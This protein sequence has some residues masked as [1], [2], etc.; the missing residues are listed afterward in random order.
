MK[1]HELGS[2]ARQASSAMSLAWRCSRVLILLAGG[3]AAV[4]GALPV[5]AG[6]LMKSLL[7][8][9]TL[10]EAQSHVLPLA[11]PLAVL[12]VLQAALPHAEQYVRTEF[13]RRVGRL[14]QKE[15]FSSI[16]RFVGMGP[17]ED[18]AFLDRLRLAQRSGSEGP[19]RAVT[20]MVGTCRAVITVVG[21]LGSLMFLGPVMGVCV[22]LFAIPVVAAEVL[23]SRRR[24]AMLWAVSPTERREHFYHQLLSSAEAAKEVRLFG[25]GGFLLSRMQR[26]R[27]AA[28]HAKRSM[29]RR[30]LLVQTCLVGTAAV[31]VGIGLVWAIVQAQ[32]GE[33]SVG[34]ISIFV[35]AAAG[36]QMALTQLAA[37]VGGMHQAL[38][39][40]RHYMEISGAGP[41]LAVSKNP[42]TLPRLRDSI[43]LR[44]V[45][46]RYSDSH[47]WILR[48]VNLKIRQGE[49]L[50]VVGLNG[51]GKS[52]L[53]KLLCRFY[54][55]TRG[56]VRWDGVDIREVDPTALRQRMAAV[57]QD[58]MQYDLTVRENIGLGELSAM[59]DQQRIERAARLAGVDRTVSDLP[60]G[61]ETLLTRFFFSAAEADNPET[62]VMLSGG[63]GQR[64]AL[65]RGFVRGDRD[66][67][68]LD[69]PS[70]GLDAEAEHEIHSSLKRHRADR[71]SLLISHRLGSVRDADRIVV[72][73]DG[74]IMEEGDHRTLM[75]DK[76]EYARLF[77]LQ[78]SGYA[79]DP[80]QPELAGG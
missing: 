3:L 42:R 11:V 36:V 57:F 10:G 79:V 15:L 12:G 1:F 44:D 14:A 7:D 13:D 69:E 27:S 4:S 28:D 58:Y 51:S 70:S 55:P 80:A 2:L 54:D 56:S 60:H 64:I 29:D 67:M 38:T 5:A 78:A 20:S 47:P 71:T 26:E 40:Y 34:D 22:L 35:A 43:E 18:P 74:R 50:A 25:T 63:Q 73:S 59:D 72:L 37:E 6:W 61:Y 33:L 48:G 31:A 24:G 53:V 21:F 9:L 30:Q 45:W 62:G 65:A 77:S 8:R 39:L 76:G 68:I 75:A 52:T 46:F 49:S 23:L 17:F 19:K 16:N 66:F 41:E 32:R